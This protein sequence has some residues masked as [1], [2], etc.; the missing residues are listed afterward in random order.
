MR[1]ADLK[2]EEYEDSISEAEERTRR[3]LFGRMQKIERFLFKNKL[4]I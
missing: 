2:R 1:S 3:V 4:K